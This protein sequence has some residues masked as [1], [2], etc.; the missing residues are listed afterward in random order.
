MTEDRGP[1]SREQGWGSWGGDSQL[2]P[3]SQGAGER[4]M[5][6][7]RVWGGATAKIDFDAFLLKNWHQLTTNNAA[8]LITN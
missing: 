8:Q 4:C 6:P 2:L 7:Q 5:L 1:K 3:T